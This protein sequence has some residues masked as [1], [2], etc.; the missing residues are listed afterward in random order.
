MSTDRGHLSRLESWCSSPPFSCYPQSQTHQAIQVQH[1]SRSEC[2]SVSVHGETSSRFYLTQASLKPLVLFQR[3][4]RRSCT[5]STC[6]DL[7]RFLDSFCQPL[8]AVRQWYHHEFYELIPSG[9][10]WISS[11]PS[12]A[13]T[14]DFGDQRDIYQWKRISVNL[15]YTGKPL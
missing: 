2:C 1:S 5:T 13:I 3:L 14:P 4:A 9:Q 8:P 7:Q 6:S 15:L 12:A 11:S 10:C